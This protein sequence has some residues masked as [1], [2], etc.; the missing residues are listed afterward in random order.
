M[1]SAPARGQDCRRRPSGCRSKWP[2]RLFASDGE[3]EPDRAGA[4]VLVLGGDRHVV[5]PFLSRGSLSLSVLLPATPAKIS[6]RSFTEIVHLVPFLA[7]GLHTPLTLW[8]VTVRETTTAIVAGRD[9]V[10]IRLVPLLAAN[11]L[12][13]SRT[14]ESAGTEGVAV[15]VVVVV[16]VVVAVV[17]VPRFGTV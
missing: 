12:E 10:N 14:A 3:R 7:A 5:S 1:D 6:A 16:V 2:T 4:A 17:V 8:P 9:R 13:R 11:L 15:L